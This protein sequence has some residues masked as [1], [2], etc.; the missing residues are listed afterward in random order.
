MRRGEVLRPRDDLWIRRVDGERD[1][2]LA[3][4][5]GHD[6]GAVMRARQPAGDGLLRCFD[7]ARYVLAH[8]APAIAGVRHTLAGC[9][10]IAAAMAEEVMHGHVPRVGA[11]RAR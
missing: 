8:H 1:P 9:A 2:H 10:A 6:V 5:R 7:T 11:G 3:E 4:S